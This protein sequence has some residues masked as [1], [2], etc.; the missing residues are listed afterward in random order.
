WRVLQSKL[1]IRAPFDVI[2]LDATKIRGS[3]GRLPDNESDRPVLLT[4]WTHDADEH[5]H[6]TDVKE[7]LLQRLCN[8]SNISHS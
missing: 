6:M 8:A 3:H 4:S 2:S 7:L 5:I 1:G